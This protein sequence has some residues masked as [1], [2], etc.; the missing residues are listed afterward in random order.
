MVVNGSAQDYPVVDRRGGNVTRSSVWH[1]VRV[2]LPVSRY[3]NALPQYRGSRSDGYGSAP[4]P[5]GS[6][7]G[8][9]TERFR[10]DKARLTINPST[11]TAVRIHPTRVR[12]IPRTFTLTARARIRPNAIRAMLDPI[13]I[14]RRYPSRR[15]RTPLCPLPQGDSCITRPLARRSRFMLRCSTN[16]A[17]RCW[18]TFFDVTPFAVI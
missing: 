5:Y 1:S 6:R 4:G 11:P 10:R 9:T 18:G 14:V 7:A 3:R 12:S 13:L 16:R 15:R 8:A 17:L 2:E